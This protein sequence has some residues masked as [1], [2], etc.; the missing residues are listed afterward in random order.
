MT[1]KITNYNETIKNLTT[2][3]KDL[4]EAALDDN[5]FALAKFEGTA[6]YPFCIVGGWMKGF[7][8]GYR[9]LLCMSKTNPDHAMCVKIA[10]NEEQETPDFEALPFPIDTNGKIEDLCIALEQED[11]FESLAVFLLTEWERITEEHADL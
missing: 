9:D 4:K 8:E 5:C 10:I 2:W 6:D 1:T 3:I 11:D 7:Q